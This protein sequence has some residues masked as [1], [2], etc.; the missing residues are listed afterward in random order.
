MSASID[1]PTL[2]H[3][4]SVPSVIAFTGVATVA[5]IMGF[6]FMAPA[7][8]LL[9]LGALWFGAQTVWSR[10]TARKTHGFS[11]LSMA[12]FATLAS[13]LGFVFLPAAGAL[14]AG[15]SLWIAL[16]GSLPQ[17][18]TAPKQDPAPSGNAAF[19]A[20]RADTLRR[21]EEERQAFAGFLDR[22]RA[23]K[24]KAEFDRFLAARAESDTTRPA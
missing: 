21:L 15:L 20:Y 22:L 14:I 2:V 10:E 1:T 18:A 23:S 8:A 5:A 6:V 13:I 7:G 24:D 16:G 4:H 3:A 9:S 12:G 17:P 19:D 11:T